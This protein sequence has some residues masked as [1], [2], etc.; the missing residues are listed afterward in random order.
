MLR[1]VVRPIS[2]PAQWKSKLAGLQ[3]RLDAALGA[4]MNMLRSMLEAAARSDIAASGSFGPR[5]TD[6]LHVG[7]EGA[8]ANMRLSMTHEIPYA[9]IFETGGVIT[10]S[11]LLWIPLQGTDAAGVRA[12]AF[13]GGL[14][15]ARYPRTTG[16]PLLFA[17]A[18]RKPRYF[19]IEQVT[20]PRKWHLK[21]DVSSVVENFKQVFD[22]SWSNASD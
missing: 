21:E 15:S 18:D 12:S 2:L 16:R 19:G 11:P 10:G 1:I 5:W 13:P 8:G 20:I 3:S 22:Q 9:S 4:T 14:F 7:I 6:G 17:A